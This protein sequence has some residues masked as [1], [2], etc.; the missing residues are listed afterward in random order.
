MRGLW[1]CDLLS[2]LWWKLDFPEI[3]FFFIKWN[4]VANWISMEVFLFSVNHSLCF[5][6]LL[7]EKERK[8]ERKKI[9]RWPNAFL[10]GFFFIVFGYYCRFFMWSTAIFIENVYQITKIAINIK[11]TRSSNRIDRTS[12]ERKKEDK[13]YFYIKKC[14]RD[15]CDEEK[16]SCF[17]FF[18]SFFLLILDYAQYYKE[19]KSTVN[20]VHWIER[21]KTPIVKLL[22]VMHYQRI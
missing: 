11:K 16:L 17:F 18:I 14:H 4:Y 19:I 12:N 20:H 15:E 10:F 22:N 1:W 6:F 7:N 9:S 13:N 2:F 3:A 21:A 8:I 5:V